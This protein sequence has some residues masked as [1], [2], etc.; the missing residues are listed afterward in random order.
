MNHILETSAQWLWVFVLHL[1]LT[2]YIGLPA[3]CPLLPQD[4]LD[5]MCSS[6]ISVPPTRPYLEQWQTRE[7][8]VFPKGKYKD[9]IVRLIS[10]C[11]L[12]G[13]P[14]SVI[15]CF[16]ASIHTKYWGVRTPK[17]FD[18]S[19]L[20]IFFGNFHSVS[21]KHLNLIGIWTRFHLHYVARH[22]SSCHNYRIVNPILFS[23]WYQPL[24]HNKSTSS[25]SLKDISD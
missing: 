4:T 14:S 24:P 3:G 15:H 19:Q 17:G 20:L 12:L 1:K 9:K 13:T 8:S 5:F 6:W 16:Y 2:K 11:M 22:T 21:E 25:C 23:W 18:K 10:L 7:S